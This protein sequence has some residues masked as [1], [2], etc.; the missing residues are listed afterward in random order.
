MSPTDLGRC[1]GVEETDAAVR[2]LFATFDRVGLDG[3]R[4]ASTQVADSSTYVILFEQDEGIED[5][6]LEIPEYATACVA[7]YLDPWSS[8]RTCSR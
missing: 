6:P 3:V 2:D 5:P 7:S 4:Y 8:A 1:D